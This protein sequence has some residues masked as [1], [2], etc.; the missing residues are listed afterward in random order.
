MRTRRLVECLAALLLAG[1]AG[2]CAGPC[3]FYENAYG[4]N[5]PDR[6]CYCAGPPAP[7]TTPPGYSTAVDPDRL[8]TDLARPSQI[9]LPQPGSTDY[10]SPEELPPDATPPPEG[11]SPEGSS[12]TRFAPPAI[13]PAGYSAPIDSPRRRMV[14]PGEISA[15]PAFPR[16]RWTIE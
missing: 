12:P 3:R 6:E 16:P 9:V 14:A 13:V 8:A 1:A 15:P 11:R 5:N 2:C 4:W 7:V 10:D